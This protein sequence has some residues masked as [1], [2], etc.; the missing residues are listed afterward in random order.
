MDFSL[1]GRTT[2]M[3][4]TTQ[5]LTATFGPDVAVFKTEVVDVRVARW[6][7]DTPDLDVNDK[8]RTK[9]KS[10]LRTCSNTTHDTTYKLGKDL[11][12]D[13]CGRLIAQ[14]TGLQ[15]HSRRVR[16]A[17]SQRHYWDV[18]MRNAQ[19]TILE[20]LATRRGWVCE[21]VK[22]YTAKREELL[23]EIG[24]SL[25]IDRDEAKTRVNALFFGGSS[26]GLP[27]FFV[28]DLGPELRTLMKNLCDAYAKEYPKEAKRG[29]KALAAIVLQTEERRVLL[30]MDSALGRL[31]RSLD[32]YIH[33][34]GLVRKKE[35]ELEFP[36]EVLRAVEADV[37]RTTGYAVEYVVKPM[38]TN[39]VMPEE[40]GGDKDDIAYA[41][42][43]RKWEDEGFKDYITFYLREQSC[44]VKVGTKATDN[45]LMKG[46][47]DLLTDEE[48]NPLP[49]GE[50][51][52]KRWFADPT[53]RE[54]Y[55]VDFLP[56]LDVPDHTYNLFRGFAV[57]PVAG[58]YSAFT[59]VLDLVSGKND[60]VAEYI[61]K[62]MAHML[63]HPS[64]KTGICIIVKGAKG[65]GKDTYFDGIGRII[66]NKH[67]LTTAKPESEVFGKFNSQL[68]QL[69]FLKFEEANFETNRDNEDQLK[70]L[71]TSEFESI[72]RKGHDAIRTT[73]CVNCVMTTNKHIPIPMSDDERRFML[74][75][76]SADRKGDTEFW[77]RIQKAVR[78]PAV[79][80]AYA[81]HLLTMDISDFEPTTIVRTR[82]YDDLLQ[83]SCPYHARFFQRLLEGMDEERTEPYVW[84]A[85]NLFAEMKQGMKLTYDITEAR[86][87]RDM[88]VYDE[89]TCLRKRRLGWGNEYIVYPQE[90][91]T[92]LKGKGWWV[93]Y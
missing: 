64:K 74:V 45:I 31:G 11:K 21:A 42:M 61:E 40:A 28:N 27:P 65:I 92:F 23:T 82:Y 51:F 57:S 85:R 50:L 67:Y 78:D 76:A 22:R 62:W 18:D 54:Y 86:F 91:V 24:D 72:E 17:L 71:I 49:S 90:M 8:E 52:V 36:A 46:K 35:G 12:H 29:V 75:E 58:D 20:Q 26:M 89:G 34:G 84:S 48:A 70:K 80:G 10:L 7:L 13:D 33:D 44:F 37:L 19:P 53:R 32:V 38:E 87:G 15:L 66:G 73:S 41:E 5:T 6:I 43:K 14:K 4:T 88:R 1:E 93:D 63:Q 55:K 56:G 47:G 60:K 69:L 39:L 16:N 68:S 77:S 79:L 3:A 9:L 81:H 83:S 2:L 25:G 59:E 30:A